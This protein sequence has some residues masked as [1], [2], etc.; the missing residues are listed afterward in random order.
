MKTAILILAAGNSTRMGE[1]KQLLSYQNTTLLGWAI[2]TAKNTATKEVF[3]VLGAHAEII[4][5]SIEKYQIETIYNP[6]YKNGLSSS[7][8]TG[9]KYLTSKNFDSVLILLA[10]QPK[11]TSGYLDIL[12][13]TA[14]E[15]STKI[16][17][18]NYK[19]N[20]GVPAIFPKTYFNQLINL[21]GD[22]G[23]K[24]LLNSVKD[25]L[26]INAT[27]LVDIDTKEDYKNLMQ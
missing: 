15:N 10:D 19:E 24:A 12:L 2:K 7:I 3:C 1:A 14:K 9:I 27:N 22:K 6:N 5:K 18:S 25:I 17:A 11:I 23:A 4:K 26:K 8:S 13:N 16:V 21:S 20:S